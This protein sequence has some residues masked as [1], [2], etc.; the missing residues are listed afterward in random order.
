MGLLAKLDAIAA[1]AV[2]GTSMS[3]GRAKVFGTV[4][5]ALIMQLINITVN[6]NNITYEYAQV[7]KAIII[8]FAVYIQRDKAA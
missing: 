3:G 4:I 7:F 1:V 5:G 6:M 8:V 2:G